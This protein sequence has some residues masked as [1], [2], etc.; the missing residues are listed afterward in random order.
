[1]E[2]ALV[3][4]GVAVLGGAAFSLAR[5]FVSVPVNCWFCSENT[6]VKYANR[7]S[8]T[9]RRWENLLYESDKHRFPY[10]NLA[11]FLFYSCGQYN[12]FSPD[13]DY[14]REIPEQRVAS[15]NGPAQY[16]DVRNVNSKD[17]KVTNG[18]CRNCNLNQE[19]K[20]LQVS[21]HHWPKSERKCHNL[22]LSFNI[23]AEKFYTKP[24]RQGR[25]RA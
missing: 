20:I 22:N 9:C 13:G 8:W 14:N 1:M 3:A 16:A 7:N 11:F 2:A 6:V 12:G 10:F 23:V 17:F 4:S 19:L 21:K 18:L 24:S 5:S 15:K 25:L